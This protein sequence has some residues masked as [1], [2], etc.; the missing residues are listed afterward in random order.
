MKVD[1]YQNCGNP[2]KR[3]EIM[4]IFPGNK[5]D[6]RVTNSLEDVDDIL[7]CVGPVLT[8]I[9]GSLYLISDFYRSVVPKL[10]L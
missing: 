3:H 10:K 9:C 6:I 8:I 5:M 1:R 2:T 7:P 4:K